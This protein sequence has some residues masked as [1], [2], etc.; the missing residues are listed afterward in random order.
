MGPSLWISLWFYL[1]F[2]THKSLVFGENDLAYVSVARCR[3]QCLK[4]NQT[5]EDDKIRPTG[6]AGLS[7]SVRI[8][9]SV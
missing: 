6:A 2:I 3:I 1:G 8:R 5:A 9:H 4:K 7:V